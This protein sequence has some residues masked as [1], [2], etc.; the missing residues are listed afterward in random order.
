[1]NH[2]EPFPSLRLHS[3]QTPDE[4]LRSLNLTGEHAQI[5]CKESAWQLPR[6]VWETISAFSNTTGG[7][8]LLGIAE[9]QGRFEITGLIDAPKIQH[10]LAS[11]LRDKM[12]VPIPAQVEPIIVPVDD[13]EH[14]IPSVYIPE[15][16]PYQ[17]PIYV[18][19]AGLDKGCYKRVAGHDMPCTED[20][21]ARFFQAR[22]FIS[23]DMT[24]VP[25]ARRE[26]LDP[27]QIRAFRQLLATQDPTN[28]VLTYDDDDLLRAYGALIQPERQEGSVPTVAGV[29]M[30][31]TPALIQRCFPAFRV[32]LIEVKGT[33]W[34]AAP[35]DRGAGR[36]FQEPLLEV[37]RDVLRV[38]RK[39]IPE[40][41]ALR[42]GE[43]Q[44]MAD[45]MHVALREAV[46]NA[47]MHQDYRIHRPTQVRRF[48]D[49]LEIENPGAS[50]RDPDR[51]G[52]PGSEL[53]NPRIAQMFY[54]IGWAEQKGTGIRAMQQAMNELGLTP[55]TFESDPQDRSFR[56]TF[57]RH[58]FMDE[59]DLAWLERFGDL[60]LSTEEQKALVYARK[61]GRADNAAFR[62]LNHT[63][64]LTA[65]RALTHL[66]NLG[67]LRRS[68]QRRG[69]GVYYTLV[70][71]ETPQSTPQSTSKTRAELLRLLSE[72]K[73]LSRDE[74]AALIVLLCNERPHTARELA[75]ILYRNVNYVRNA[76]LSPLVRK[77]RLQL[78]GA[79]ND[80]NVAYRSAEPLA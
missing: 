19:S 8:L 74:T 22:S 77:G 5:E 17:K 79:P 7:T 38:L 42:P 25:M 16:L 71:E 52:E 36:A 33:E 47:L 32:D 56:V 37:V 51:L 62:S 40:R 68:E 60:P 72:G 13:Q 73:R 39:E 54:E 15:A 27:G 9:R 45:P 28:P 67:L 80:P 65:S 61:T 76:Y 55:P 75:K 12:N 3:G 59:S 64:T 53:R 23:P 30:F 58:H 66:E 44:R 11:G 21:L 69:P 24:P 41:F 48:A 57:Y 34:V 78:T 63:D 43:A 31:G 18:R 14:V 46:H 4:L 6:D 35:T 10:D 26:E 70:E 2:A 29:L 20:D 49:R 1:M 50:L